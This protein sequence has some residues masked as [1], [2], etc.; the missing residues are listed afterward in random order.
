MQYQSSPQASIV[1][2]CRL[3]MIQKFVFHD[4]FVSLVRPNVLF[5]IV[6]LTPEKLFVTAG[7]LQN[8]GC[9]FPDE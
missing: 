6:G 8:Q 9:K 5:K 2:L 1:K 7:G 4:K 3:D